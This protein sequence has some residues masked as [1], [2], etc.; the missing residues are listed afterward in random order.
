MGRVVFPSWAKILTVSAIAVL[1][2]IFLYAVRDMLS[3]FV[4]AMIVAYVFNPVVTTFSQK[5]RVHR[6]WGVAL[7]YALMAGVVAAAMIYLIPPLRHESRQFWRDLPRLIE[8][9]YTYLL[10]QDTVRIWGVEIASHT[11][12]AE[13]TS[14]LQKMGSSATTYVLPVFFGVLGMATKVLMFLLSLFYFLLEADK[15]GDF[16]RK[17]VPASGR[18]EILTVSAEID[19]VL[20]RWVRGQLVLILIMSS[21]T[22]ITLTL[23]GVRYALILALL[24]GM[25]EIFPIIGP[26]IAGTIACVVALFQTNPFGWSSITYVAVIAAVYFVLRHAEDYFVI[27]NVI[28]RIVEFHPLAVLFALFAGGSIAGILGMFI[29]APTLAVL[30]IVLRYLYT[31]LVEPPTAEVAAEPSNA[32]EEAAELQQEIAHDS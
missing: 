30:K 27:P 32:L 21:V 5:L 14:A 18:D 20:G 2:I 10:G 8:S 4:W 15:I 9:L 24:T 12:A 6:F 1:S 28:G 25:L 17:L 11:L 26:V 23:L 19:D 7:L 22:A 3:P 31:K 29:A 13:L 16:L